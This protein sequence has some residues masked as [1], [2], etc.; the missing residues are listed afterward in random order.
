MSAP[1]RS[2][3]PLPEIPD[4]SCSVTASQLAAP[5]TR[6]ISSRTCGV[7]S[8]TARIDGSTVTG[9]PIEADSPSGS[10]T[11]T[12]AVPADTPVTGVVPDNATFATPRSGDAAVYVKASPSGSLKGGGHVH[13]DGLARHQALR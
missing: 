13:C 1:P 5:V 3:T 7:R 6:T 9:T 10:V 12:A 8:H 4:R 2:S 11:V